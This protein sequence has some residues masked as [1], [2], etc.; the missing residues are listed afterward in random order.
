MSTSSVLPSLRTVSWLNWPHM[1]VVLAGIASIAL[2]ARL[3][4]RVYRIHFHPLK[5][6]KGPR[7]A[8]IS[9]QWLYKTTKDG[10]AE[11]VF[12]ALHAKYNTKALRIGPNELH[13]TDIELYKVIYNQTKP[14]LKHAPFYDGF[15]TPHTVF[16]ELDPGLHK[17]R[18]RMLSPFFSKVGVYRLEPLIYEKISLLSSKIN[19]LCGSNKIDIYNGFRLLTTEIITQFAFAKSANLIEEKTDGLESWFLDAF[20]VGSQSVVDTQYSAFLRQL[21]TILPAGVV[22]ML[23]PPLRSILDL[24]KYAQSCMYHWQK[25]S[26]ESSYPVIFDSLQSISDEAKI[27]EAMDILIAGADTTASTLTTGFYHII[28]S[29]R[30]KERLVQAI[31]QVMPENGTFIP[32]QS[33]EKVEYLTACVKESMRLG[34]AVPGRLPRV[35]PAGDPFVVEG[36]VVPPG[37]IVSISAYTMH[38]SED[39]WGSDAR[40]FNPDRWS[41]PASKGL[42]QC[43]AAAEITLV[44]AYIF[45]NYELSFPPEHVSPKALDR[46][47]LQYEKPGLPVVFTPRLAYLNELSSPPRRYRCSVCPASFQRREHFDRHFHR[48]SKIKDFTCDVCHKRFA[49]R[50][51]LQRHSTIHGQEP[52][53]VLRTLPRAPRACVSCV[54]SKQRCSGSLPCTRCNRKN[55]PCQF[56]KS[57]AQAASGGEDAA[58]LDALEQGTSSSQLNQSLTSYDASST[59]EIHYDSGGPDKTNLAGEP[60][61]DLVFPSQPRPSIPESDA[62]SIFES[63]LLWPLDDAFEEHD[64]GV[65]EPSTFE[66]MAGTGDQPAMNMPSGAETTRTLTPSTQ[67]VAG[68]ASSGLMILS[69]AQLDNQITELPLTEEDRD[70]LI[71]DDYG[72][73]PKPSAVTYEQICALHAEVRHASPDVILPRLYSLDI[74]HICTQLYFEHFHRRFPI[75]HQHT[76]EAKSESWLLYLAV[77]AV[78]SQ[79]SRLSIRAKIFSDLVKIIRVA[80]LRKLNSALSLQNNLGLA[81]ATLLFNLALLFGGTREGIMHLQYQRN[82][83]V[84]MC[85]PL[86]VPNVLFAKSYML[87]A[88]SVLIT[89]WT[90]WIALES[91]KRVVYFTWLIECLHVILFDLPALIT[92]GDMHLSMPCNDELWQLATFQGWQR[93]RAHHREQEECPSVL[94]LLQTQ[95]LHSGHIQPLSDSALW[96]SVFSIYVA[97][98]HAYPPRPFLPQR[99]PSSSTRLATYQGPTKDSSVDDILARFQQSI[100]PPHRHTSPIQPIVLKFTLLLR[101]LRFIPYRLM[102]VSAGWMAQPE[103]AQLA[104]H[105]ITQLLH[106]N[107]KEARQSLIHAAQLFRL[108]RLQHHLDPFDSFLLLMA[109]LYIWNYDKFVILAA[110]P[111]PPPA[112]DGKAGDVFRIDQSLPVDSQERW[113]AGTFEAC[114]LHIS[115]VGVLDGR[116]SPSRILRES[117]RILDQ[118]GSWSRQAKAIR[119]AL[120]QMSVG[121]VPTFAEPG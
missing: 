34:M 30:C 90:R 106:T 121:G 95:D 70:I 12:E 46:F 110:P 20:D 57:S 118:D 108:I 13:I 116:D 6:F 66:P 84:T 4:L 120:H 82:V 50:D 24:Q 38:N 103:D 107:P 11:Q 5:S 109:V 86:L 28:S 78:G 26:T 87:S 102:Y 15:N 42:E 115:G 7:D 67:E 113:I 43:V 77:A 105:H 51:T 55:R 36:K 25:L 72:H 22:G 21:V 58:L 61:A 117:M 16:A 39:A 60:C 76:F 74:L 17:E 47:T 68:R 33:L 100:P 80:L 10:T 101:L 97:E 59:G 35:V 91:W 44:F 1:T 31:D 111:P 63:F 94:S 99:H 32:L 69:S 75:L 37:T 41:G 83:L 112:S 56:A 54:K 93:T 29:P 14:F 92:V 85:R 119:F 9:E 45:R 62:T 64:M 89:D 18:R 88:A 40:E 96:M 48:H 2:A 19:R 53:Q 3:A 71:S 81:Q 8:C 79:Y 104:S 73:V 27:A 23:N 49:R 98:R 114:R 65:A 52:T